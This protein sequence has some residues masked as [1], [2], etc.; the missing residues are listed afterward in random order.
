MHIQP[1]WKSVIITGALI[2]MSTARVPVEA[3]ERCCFNNFRYSGGCMVVTGG[4]ETCGDVLAYLNDF[5]SVGKYYC[6]NT[7][8]RGGWSLSDCGDP[9]V[10]TQPNITPEAVQPAAPATVKPV[11]PTITQPQTAQPAQ[12]PSLMQVSAPLEVRVN[13]DVVSG[14][15]GAGQTV[16]GTL[17]EDLVSGGTLIAPAGSEVLF[18]IVPTSYWEDGAGDAFEI[19]ATAIKAGDEFIPISA[20]GVGTSGAELNIPEGSL[21]SFET[22][23]VDQHAAE[24]KALASFTDNWMTAFN[25]RDVDAMTALHAEDAV[26]LPPDAPAVF[27]RDAIRAAYVDLFAAGFAIELEDLEIKVSGDLGYKAGRYRMTD[28]TG[29]LVDRG[30]Y[31]DI[32]SKKDGQWLLHRDIWNSS[33][34]KATDT[35]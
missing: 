17:E 10:N 29:T 19:Q 23:A 5:N 28:K 12:A 21:V 30:K 25:T 24:E 9:A 4:N 13:S 11:N 20:V 7:T 27:G 35:E 22:R 2:V 16:T 18:R 8:I 31:I 32:W 33:R 15:H 1:K 3:G 6:D 14:S 26:L 34:Q